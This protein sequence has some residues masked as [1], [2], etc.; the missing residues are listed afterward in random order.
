MQVP[1]CRDTVCECPIMCSGHARGSLC[2]VGGEFEL[3]REYMCKGTV[4]I[5]RPAQWVVWTQVDCFLK[6]GNRFADAPR[7]S[8]RV[9][10]TA[11]GDRKAGVQ[12]DRR[13]QFG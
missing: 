12:I 8:Q 10:E 4:R 6:I 2:P 5:E 1:Q 11:I 13:L 9:A 7:V 3:S